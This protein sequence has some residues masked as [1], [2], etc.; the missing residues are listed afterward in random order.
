[1]TVDKAYFYE[2]STLDWK[3]TRTLHRFPV[4]ASPLAL[5]PDADSFIITSSNA[6]KLLR[7][8]TGEIHDTLV[9]EL[10]KFNLAAGGFAA[11]GANNTAFV[12]QR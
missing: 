9:P 5:N 10:P 1:M 3:Q 2:W 11:F 4:D 12:P 7:L 8:S 6:F